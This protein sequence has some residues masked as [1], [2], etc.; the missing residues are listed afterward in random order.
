[1]SSAS[2][3]TISEFEAF[4]EKATQDI[5]R[6]VSDIRGKSGVEEWKMAV[7]AI[8]K[9]LD[10]VQAKYLPCP[11][12]PLVVITAEMQMFPINQVF[13]RGWP[14]L[15]AILKPGLE[16]S[17]H[18]WAQ[19]P[20]SILKGKGVDPLEWGGP[21]EAGGSKVEGKQVSDGNQGEKGGEK[22]KKKKE[23]KEKKEKKTERLAKGSDEGQDSGAVGS[24]LGVPIAGGDSGAGTAEKTQG[25]TWERKPK[26]QSQTKSHSLAP[27]TP[28]K[29]APS[30]GPSPSTS[31]KAKA[32]VSKLRPKTPLVAQKAKFGI[33]VGVTPTD[34]IKVHHP[35]AGPPPQSIP[36]ASALKLIA[37]PVNPLLDAQP[38]TSSNPK[39][40]IIK[41]LKLSSMAQV[42]EALWEQVT[43]PAYISLSPDAETPF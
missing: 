20:K 36:W 18:I 12:V 3:N 28:S 15:Q 16:V 1:M 6:T 25:Q 30:L 33:D 4:A 42:I 8:N 7:I 43:G 26:K 31:K 22:G 2:T 9:I 14:L 24:E 38:V 5:Q 29:Q 13:T 27:V 10:E 40:Q 21:M 19:V 41:A 35:L 37:T 34:S 39:D 11:K 32:S 23:K 17:T